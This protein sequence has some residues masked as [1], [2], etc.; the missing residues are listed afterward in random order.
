MTDTVLASHVLY[1]GWLS[2][3]ML[4]LR[5]GDIECD[6]AIVEHV[7]GATV[8]A[9]DPDRRV[10]MTVRQ[11]R[12]AVLYLGGEPFAEAIAGV[13][14]SEAPIDTARREAFEETG[15]ALRSVEAVAQV[16]MTPSSTTER[17]HLFLAEYRSEDRIGAGGGAADEIETIDAREEPLADLWDE[18]VSGRVGDAK[19]FMLLQALHLRRPELFA[20]NIA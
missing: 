18:A 12:D 9:Y 20:R 16:W 3:R 17:V 4:R 5:L 8:L 19:L 10:A 13:T 7:S 15:L 2:L 11:T 14:E 1:R 6:R